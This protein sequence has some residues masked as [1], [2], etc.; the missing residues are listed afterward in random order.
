MTKA[1][2]DDLAYIHDV[3]FG[4][5]AKTATPSLLKMLRA[6]GID[7]GLVVDLGCGSGIWA[8]ELA[9]AGY[10]VLGIDISPAMIEIARKRVP[11]ATFRVGSLLRVKIPRCAAVTSLGECV[12]YLFDE[13]NNMS[14]L[15]RL[16]NRVHSALQPGGLFIFDI[17]QPGRGKGPAQK[18]RRGKD[19]AVLLEVDEDYET[20]RL[21]RRIV[22][23]RKQGDLY[24]RDEEVHRLQ[25]YKGSDVAQ[26]LR[27]AGFRVRSLRSY[28]EQKMIGG[29]VAFHARK[30]SPVGADTRVCPTR[31]ET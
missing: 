24:R 13:T 4:E 15:R 7:K 22:S 2:K 10:D 27:E 12:N 29:C 16:F 20:N 25:L 5:F 9:R 18:H 26:A 30:A 8:R 6:N 14:Q 21:T 11:Q 28:G 17:A 23:F 1:Y 19:W 31:A 3:G